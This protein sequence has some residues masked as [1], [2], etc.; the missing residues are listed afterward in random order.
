MRTCPAAGVR[1]SRRETVARMQRVRRTR[2]SSPCW[3][4]CLL[5]GCQAAARRR[6]PRSGTSRSPTTQVDADRRGVRGGR[7]RQARPPAVRQRRPRPTCASSW[8]RRR[9]SASWPAATPRS[10]ACP[11][12]RPT[13]PPRPSRLGRAAGHPFTK[14][15]ADSDAYRQLLLSAG[16]RRCSR[17]RRTCATRT[18]ATSRRPPTPGSSPSRTRTSGPSWSRRPSTP[19]ASACATS[20]PSAAQRY[21]VEVSPRYQPLESPIW[22]PSQSQLVLVGLPLG[23]G[24]GD[25]VRDL[26]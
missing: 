22:A 19:R 18:T 3:P 17:P 20:W 1:Q 2:R 21:G 26:G 7:G 14:V 12:P 15:V 5:G 24:T 13:T 11:R 16:R 10:R 25:A 4:G 8:C 23:D 9:C 6:P